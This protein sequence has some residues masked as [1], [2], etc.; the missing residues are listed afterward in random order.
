MD[1]YEIAKQPL[2]K[3]NFTNRIMKERLGLGDNTLGTYSTSKSDAAK[4]VGSMGLS[5]P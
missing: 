1:S 5:A 4:A 2:S 3:L